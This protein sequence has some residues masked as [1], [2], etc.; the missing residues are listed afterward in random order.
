[1]LRIFHKSMPR[2]YIKVFL[3][4][5]LKFNFSYANRC[6]SLFFKKVLLLIKIIE[7]LILKI[8]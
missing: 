8:F 3:N 2:D 5:T 6:N 1:M 7:K 4:G